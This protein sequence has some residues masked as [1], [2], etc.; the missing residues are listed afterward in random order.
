MPPSPVA[1]P[2]FVGLRTIGGDFFGGDGNRNSLL[3]YTDS[4][5]IAALHYAEGPAS[6]G[7]TVQIVGNFSALGDDDV[8]IRFGGVPVTS[9]RPR[10]AEYYEVIAPPHILP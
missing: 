4:G 3:E 9:V 6:G 2:C 5:G 1:F 10:Q 7:N 8:D